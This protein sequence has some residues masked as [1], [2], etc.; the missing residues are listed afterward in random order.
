MRRITALLTILVFTGALQAV[1]P[2]PAPLHTLTIPAPGAN[3]YSSA[4]AYDASGLLH[5]WDGITVWKQDA[6]ATDAFTAIGSVDLDGAGTIDNSSDAGPITFSRDGSHMLLGN[7]FGG[8][9]PGSPP[10]DASWS[11]LVMSMPVAGGTVTNSLADMDDHWDFEPLA[12]SST[13]AGAGQKYFVDQGDGGWPPNSL[14]SIFD[15]TDQSNVPVLTGVP[16]AAAHVALDA[17]DNLYVTV[18]YGDYRGDVR[19]FPLANLESAY[20]TATPLDWS[21]GTLLNPV[22]TDNHSGAGLFVDDR[23]LLFAGGS[24]GLT[25]F[26]P[27][28][29]CRTY[30]VNTGYA[31]IVHNAAANTI[32]LM[33]TGEVYDVAAFVPEPGT[34]GLLAC[35][36]GMLL[37]GRRR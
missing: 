13:L 28:G 8:M 16:G 24:D 17:A 32:L 12:A 35:G 27:D 4:A 14:V 10:F 31:E 19:L 29:R 3:A 21:D 36:V 7:G 15:E 23:G 26:G 1:Y 22:Y 34:L 11:G 5:V 9:V 2:A 18:G 30:D 20:T 6:A 33:N 25:V 37:H